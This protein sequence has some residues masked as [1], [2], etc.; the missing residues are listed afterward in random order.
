MVTCSRISRGR[1][2]LSLSSILCN[3]GIG[4]EGLDNFAAVS[5]SSSAEERCRLTDRHP[6]GGV[7]LCASFFRVIA[8]YIPEEAVP[9]L[10]PLSPSP[11][12]KKSETLTEN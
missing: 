11:S 10:S 6:G 5:E 2:T 3:I 7:G 1:E 8:G 9:T 4:L 12:Q